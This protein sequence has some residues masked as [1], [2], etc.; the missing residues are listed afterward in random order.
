MQVGNTSV[1]L[2]LLKAAV[3]QHSSEFLSKV[4]CEI[5]NVQLHGSRQLVLYCQ[6]APKYVYSYWSVIRQGYYYVGQR[7]G[8]NKHID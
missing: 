3:I 1:A 4:V 5:R 7:G 8:E 6:N 2:L